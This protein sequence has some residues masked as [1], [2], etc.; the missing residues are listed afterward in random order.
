[1]DPRTEQLL[2]DYR[3][4]VEK[5]ARGVYLQAIA[6]KRELDNSAINPEDKHKLLLHC[7]NLLITEQPQK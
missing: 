3:K 4:S 1:M 5:L 7:I 2:Q 6:L